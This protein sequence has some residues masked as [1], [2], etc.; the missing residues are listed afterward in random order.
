MRLSEVIRQQNKDK[1][2]IS[3]AIRNKRNIIYKK[4]MNGNRIILKNTGYQK[5]GG[6]MF[7]VL[8]KN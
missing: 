5:E 6:S 4:V 1:G 2:K 8:S 7:L 3:K